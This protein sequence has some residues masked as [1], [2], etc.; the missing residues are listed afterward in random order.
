MQVFLS[1]I[2]VVAALLVAFYQVRGLYPKSR[3]RLKADLEIL[4]ALPKESQE[5]KLVQRSVN[6]AV[7]A[8]YGDGKLV[9]HSWS[10]LL[11]GLLL[12]IGGVWGTIA[13]ALD[14]EYVFSLFPL[15]FAVLGSGGV[16]NAFDP[17]E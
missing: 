11:F 7:K 6:A 8:I 12:M 16:M 9:V 3:I 15:V 4:A 14:G 2:G 13:L 1:S 10:D 17:E 5:R